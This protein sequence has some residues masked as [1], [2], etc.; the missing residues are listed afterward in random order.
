MKNTNCIVAS[1]GLLVGG[2]VLALALSVAALIL[3]LKSCDDVCGSNVTTNMETSVI[4][5]GRP[6]TR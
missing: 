6:T 1:K 4:P 5:T 2:V 3:S